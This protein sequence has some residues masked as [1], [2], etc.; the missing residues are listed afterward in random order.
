MTEKAL[1]LDR[2]GIINIDT[3]YI[4]TVEA[5]TF[6]P[7]IFR[8][9][10]LFAKHDYRIFVVT[11]QSGIGRGYYKASDFHT[12]TAWMVEVFQAEGITI[13]GVYH[14][15]HTPDKKCHCR[16]PNTGMVEAALQDYPAL[17]LKRSW[18][19]GD[20][21]SDIDLAHNSGIGH[22]IAIGKN[23]LHHA[24]YQFETIEACVAFLEENEDK[25]A[26]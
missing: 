13:A 11:N 16:K 25:I 22:T 4:H 8:L 1:F 23:A 15:P 7:G 14:C 3:G 12:L 2:D 19:V 6:M 21:Q 24:T 5:F 18:M 17:S 9:C 26:L 10:H 20:K